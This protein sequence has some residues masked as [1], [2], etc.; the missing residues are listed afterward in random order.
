MIKLENVS[1]YYYSA[2]SVIP[3]LKRIKLEFHIGE[4]V[5]ITGESGSGKS[6]L[7]SIISGLDTY[8]DGELFIE[9][10]ATSHFDDDDWEEYRKN[11]IGFVFQNYNL[12]E[13]FTALYNV[14]SSLLIQGLDS[15]EARK[16]AKELLNKVGLKAQTKERAAK[17]SSGQKQ[18]L[19]IAR[20]L[21]KNTDIIVADEPTGNLDS[22][23]G[24]QIMELFRE[25][26]KD[27]LIIIV[28]HNYD[29]IAPYVTRKIRLHDGE[30][31]ADTQVKEAAANTAEEPFE[32]KKERIAKAAILQDS[33]PIGMG[34]S[35]NSP[36][37]NLRDRDV[38]N[39]KS[40]K[41]MKSEWQIALR[42]TRMNIST[43]PR[44][45]MLFVSFLILTAGVSFLFLGE[46]YSNKDDTFTRDYDDRAFLNSDDKRIVV[47]NPDNSEMTEEDIKCFNKLKYVEMADR[48]DYANDI[49]F[50]IT[51]GKDYDYIYK[52]N[53]DPTGKSRLKVPDFLLADKFVKSST[54]LTD[55]KLRAGR[56]P[57][58]INE[59]VLYSDKESRLGEEITCY[60]TSR[61]SWGYDN[62]YMT[63]VKVVGLLNKQSEQVYFSEE[64]CNMLSL[65]MYEDSYMMYLSKNVISADYDLQLPFI[66][67]I[68]EGMKDRELK[69]SADLITT[70]EY[71]IPGASEVSVYRGGEEDGS[72][73]KSLQFDTTV[74]NTYHMH[75]VKFVEISEAWFHEL[76]Q[77]KS[78]QASLY[79]KDYIYTDYVLKKLEA[80]G[81][82]AISSYRI[83]SKKYNSWKVEQRNNALQRSALVLIILFL[84][85][86]LIIGS[87][88]RIKHNNYLILGSIGMSHRTM[89]LMNYFEMLLYTA[90]AV[91][92][93]CIMTIILNQ[94]HIGYLADRIKYYNPVT[95]SIFLFY[96]CFVIMVT[97]YMFN[98]YLKRKQKW[99]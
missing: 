24:K 3:A 31:V 58:A 40:K 93:V 68:G 53:D 97:V 42:F 65:S 79:I 4:F 26:S 49:N 59:V 8:D 15:K 70:S 29:E 39:A 75:S 88:L 83:S 10:E 71:N 91:G 90:A 92:F 17:L 13:N 45:V 74:L 43:Q 14:E 81:Y 19:S 21:A 35:T 72:S 84:L 48:Y 41:R 46:I 66:P 69:V 94:F 28:T 62:Y 50:Y 96:N 99:I 44:R 27:K 73:S 61:N 5:A 63:T 7:L 25:L 56:L 86:V 32:A 55:K 57:K 38:R 87:F 52:P 18:R 78:D 95:Y 6:T 2:N 20:A 67:V 47:K 9:E 16:K 60:F 11:K 33:G 34:A 1:K 85:E 37:K 82:H 12:I 64:L 89:K 54:C 36:T 77:Y 30:L 51:L 22:E 76:Y 80:M 98:Q 23:T